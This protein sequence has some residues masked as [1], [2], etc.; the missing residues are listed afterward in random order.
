MGELSVA[1]TAC[2]SIGGVCQV[3]GGDA[4]L[5]TQA[6]LGDSP[7]LKADVRLA[8]RHARFFLNKLIWVVAIFQH[9]ARRI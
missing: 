1:G 9:V 8:L 7:R 4:S 3:S 2:A 5:F 6:S